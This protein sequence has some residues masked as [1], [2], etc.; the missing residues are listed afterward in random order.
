MRYAPTSSKLL[1]YNYLST[2]LSANEPI[3]SA[4][5]CFHFGG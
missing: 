4:K 2:N 3:L 5:L 1:N